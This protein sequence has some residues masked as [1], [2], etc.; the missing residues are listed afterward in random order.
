MIEVQAK[1]RNAK[2]SPKK[3][4]LVAGAIRGLGVAKAQER[5]QVI[6]KKSAPVVA[7]L[8]QSAIANAKNRY[9]VNEADLVVKS[10]TVDQGRD[11]KRWR[12][13]AFGR[14]HPFSTHYCH[15]TLVLGLKA[16]ATAK[17]LDTKTAPVETVDLTKVENKA[18]AKTEAVSND[19]AKGLKEKI[20]NLKKTKTQN[21]DHK[22]KGVRVKK[23]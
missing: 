5:L 18:A 2:I 22:A 16:G 13:A 11:L 3:V 9:E 10:I 8:L 6:F 1:L 19:K 7:K 23:G 15:I 21:L 12:P 4:R 20:G 17:L 14:A